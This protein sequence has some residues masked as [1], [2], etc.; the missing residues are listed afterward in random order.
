MII[1]GHAYTIAGLLFLVA[2]AY[3]LAQNAIRERNADRNA[4][5][6]ETR[7]RQAAPSIEPHQDRKA[8]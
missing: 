8:A 3:G 6:A 4:R 1:F 2:V 7:R 5:P